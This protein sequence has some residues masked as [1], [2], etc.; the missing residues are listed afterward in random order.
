M[1]AYPYYLQKTFMYQFNP[2]LQGKERAAYVLLRLLIR[3]PSDNE[4]KIYIGYFASTN[5][6]NMY[7]GI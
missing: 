1:C 5:V 3:Q 6:Y 7:S 4:E 2:Q